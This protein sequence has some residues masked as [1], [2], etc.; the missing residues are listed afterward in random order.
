MLILVEDSWI[1][2]QTVSSRS[3]PCQVLKGHM[4]NYSTVTE[5][6]TAL[7]IYYSN[8]MEEQW[9]FIRQTAAN[10]HWLPGDPAEV[11]LLPVQRFAQFEIPVADI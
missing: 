2:M 6:C 10:D 1:D 7:N 3:R 11:G 4:K 5:L 9:H 8:M